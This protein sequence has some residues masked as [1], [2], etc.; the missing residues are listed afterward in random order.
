MKMLLDLYCGAGG[1]AMGY[2]RAGF[3]VAGV[4]IHPQP[5][6]PFWFIQADA[7]EYLTTLNEPEQWDAIHAS[8][9]CQAYTNAQRIRRRQHPDLITPTRELLKATG[10]PYL[11]ENVPGSPLTDPVVL[12]GQMF[13]GLSTIRPRWFEANWPLE[14]PFL[15]FSRP[16][17][18]KM[19]RP[20]KTD[21]WVQAGRQLLRRDP[22][23]RS[24]GNRLDDTRRAPRSHPTRLHRT[25]RQTTDRPPRTGG[26]MTDESPRCWSVTTLLDLGLAKPAF[27][28]WAARTVAETAVDRLATLRQMVEVDED[29][30]AAIDFLTGSRWRQRATV[31]KRGSRVHAAAEKLNL[32]ID[33]DVP[34]EARPYI[35][36][37]ARFLNEHQPEF[38]LAE[39][40]VYNFSAGYAGTL[41]SV[42]R[43]GGELYV[44]DVKTHDKDEDAPSRPPYPDVAL[45]L[46]AYARAEQVAIQGSAQRNWHGRRYYQLSEGA[47][48]EP[49]PAVSQT[50][51]LALAVSPTDYQLVPVRVD[52]TVWEYFLVFADAARWQLEEAGRV[53]GTPIS[54]PANKVAA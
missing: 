31:L 54:P 36:Q 11:I 17:Q 3:D 8:P 38:V 23:P 42:V 9:P 20:P 28:N 26:R 15:R 33:P 24:H 29:R 43:L 40:A 22:R 18:T 48:L 50:V 1:A 21:E 49:L 5:N 25:D 27:V 19:G 47:Q 52:A 45:Q 30:Q 7:L 53:L 37:Y 46:C 39:A 2:H 44:L 41:D 35:E 32:G 4:D 14:V 10:L 6:Y 34:E 12:E 13:D 16:R 51:A